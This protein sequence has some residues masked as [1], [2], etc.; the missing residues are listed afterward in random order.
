[1]LLDRQLRRA[2]VDPR[3]VAGYDR[4]L[5]GQLDAGRA[6]AQGF[7]D[8]AIGSASVASVYGL[9]FTALTQERCSLFVSFAGQRTPEIRALLDALRS[10]PF[11]RDLEAL[12]C[13]DVSR[14]GER[15]G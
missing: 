8:A 13:Y 4:T 7:S 9:E 1:M 6:I 5:A 14:T 10:T 12:K 11:R 3:H 2:G 15:I